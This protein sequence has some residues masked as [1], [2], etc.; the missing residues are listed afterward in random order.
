MSSTILQLQQW[1]E[2][3]CNG[4][5]EHQY[6]ISIETLDNPGWR[7]EIDLKET[8]FA[9]VPFTRIKQENQNGKWLSCWTEKDKFVGAGNPSQLVVILQHFLKWTDLQSAN[10]KKQ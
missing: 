1:Y 5:W 9:N 4:D 3:Q 6:G 7:V 2:A 10:G 8:P